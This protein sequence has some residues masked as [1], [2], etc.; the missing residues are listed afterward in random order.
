MIQI[1]DVASNN[2]GGEVPGHCLT[3]WQAMISTKAYAESQ[4]DVLRFDFLQFDPF[5]YYLDAVTVTM[6]GHEMELMKILTSLTY[7]DF[8]SNS[9]HVK[10]LMKWDNLNLYA[11]WTCP[12]MLSV[13]KSHHL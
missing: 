10:Y 13:A 12:I 9:F 4:F 11:F 7:I 8:S 5:L 2:F 6:K 3:K 1:F